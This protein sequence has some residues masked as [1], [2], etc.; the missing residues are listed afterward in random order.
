MGIELVRLCMFVFRY[1][2]YRTLRTCFGSVRYV[3]LTF[4]HPR[5]VTRFRQD[6]YVISHTRLPLHRRSEGLSYVYHERPLTF[7]LV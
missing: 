6:T 7:E 2:R 1:A 4:R 3:T 5:Y